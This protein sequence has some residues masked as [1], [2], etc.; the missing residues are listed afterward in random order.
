M[1]RTV[2]VL[3]LLAAFIFPTAAYAQEGIIY[4]DSIPAGV[5]VNHDVVLIGNN[6]FIGG[7]VNG[8]AFIL[9]N[10]VLISGTVNGSLVMLAQNAAIGGEVTGAA[11]AM[12]LTLD[13]RDPASINRDLYALTVSLT[14]KPASAVERHLFALGLDAGLNGRIG[15][16]LHTVI[17]P[18]QLY[19]GLVRLLGFNE[20]T[21]ELHFEL[22]SAPATST[23]T[24]TGSVPGGKAYFTF[25]FQA[26]LPPFDW[27]TWSM[28]ALRTWAVLFVFGLLGLWL[29]RPPLEAAGRPM[30]GRPWRT[31]GIGF[32]VLVVAFNLFI[33]A[34]LIAALIFA[35]GLGLNAIG[36]WPI[37]VA[38]WV[39]AYSAIII[40]LTALSLYIA[41]GATIVVAYHLATWLA[42]KTTWPRS[43][44]LAILALFV[45]TLIY[46]LL[47]SV[48][49]AGWIIGL[50][51]TALGMGSAWL[52]YREP[53]RVAAVQGLAVFPR[54]APAIKKS[55]A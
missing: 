9:G 33:V 22:P 1:K 30:L 46:T 25:R 39:V 4:G 50:L 44:W 36:L 53:A 20:L 49:Y 40:A 31:L 17:G 27:S 19:N 2:L 21:L 8:N 38:L 18:I 43:I 32:I 29:L 3:V 26:P 12:A 42:H 37:S 34:L 13:L 47:R 48:P 5:T 55:R 11:Y 24:G 41:Y 51:V 15:G 10:Q 35:I 7:V 6:V 52:A 45:G 23:P 28:N 14:S 54:P 16:D